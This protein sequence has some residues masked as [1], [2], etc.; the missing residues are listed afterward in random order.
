MLCII[1]SMNG[2]VN[3]VFRN[4]KKRESKIPV[5]KCKVSVSQNKN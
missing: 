3:G 5:L 4:K 2:D 1:R